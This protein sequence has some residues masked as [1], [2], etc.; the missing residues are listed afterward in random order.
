MGSAISAD[1]AR[2]LARTARAPFSPLRKPRRPASLRRGSVALTRL[3]PDETDT[4]PTTPLAPR[5][6]LTVPARALPPDPLPAP[7]PGAFP[8]PLPTP[9]PRRSGSATGS[10]QLEDLCFKKQ[11]EVFTKGKGKQ[12]KTRATRV[13]LDFC[14]SFSGLASAP[15]APAVPFHLS[16]V[17]LTHHCDTLRH[18]VTG[19]L[20]L[21]PCC[22]SFKGVCGRRR[23]PETP[24]EL[25]GVQR[26]LRGSAVREVSWVEVSAGSSPLA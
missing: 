15:T 13:Q 8:A 17:Y 18:N 22:S 25:P 14:T 19:P 16:P 4:Q 7:P 3:L 12:N 24:R 9:G 2:A 6:A 5:S 10:S 21:A 26:M 1:A 11:L 23:L 20:L